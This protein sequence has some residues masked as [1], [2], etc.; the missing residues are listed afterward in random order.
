[1]NGVISLRCS[2]VG[3]TRSPSSRV[4]RTRVKMSASTGVAGIKRPDQFGWFGRYGG[5]Y[6]PETLIQNLR[7]L[8]REY[9]IVKTDKSFQVTPSPVASTI[10]YLNV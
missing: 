1:M 7:E 10:Y 4:A 5:Q 2:R 3:K 8:E 9:N 6:V